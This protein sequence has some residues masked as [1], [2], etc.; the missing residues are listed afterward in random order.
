MQFTYLHMFSMA[1]NF[2]LINFFSMCSKNGSPRLLICTIS[3]TILCT[4]H[5][6]YVCIDFDC[7]PKIYAFQLLYFNSFSS[8]L[9][10]ECNVLHLRSDS[11]CVRSNGIVM[12]CINNIQ[13]IGI[14]ILFRNWM[15][16]PIHY[17]RSRRLARQSYTITFVQFF[18]ENRCL[19]HEMTNIII[20]IAAFTNDMNWRPWEVSVQ[21]VEKEWTWVLLK[22]SKQEVHSKIFLG[23]HE[24]NILERR[25]RKDMTNRLLFAHVNAYNSFTGIGQLR[26]LYFNFIA[27]I[28]SHISNKNIITTHGRCTFSSRSLFVVSILLSGNAAIICWNCHKIFGIWWP[29]TYAVLGAHVLNRNWEAIFNFLQFERPIHY[30]ATS[31]AFHRFVLVSRNVHCTHTI[32][33]FISI[34]PCP[35]SRFKAYLY[36]FLSF[37]GHTLP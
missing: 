32:V 15:K 31:L 3:N 9:R 18:S 16:F 24:A 2:A 35:W 13:H 26:S 14:V 22:D 6:T 33:V 8:L 19:F 30:C 7:I 29:P 21:D 27:F 34:A 20:S 28:C 25:D 4:R 17:L 12:S 5:P 1:C 11:Q 37:V 36:H 10:V 23:A